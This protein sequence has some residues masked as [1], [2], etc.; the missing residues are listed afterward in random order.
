[1][2]GGIALILGVYTRPLRRS[3]AST[4]CLAA[5]LAH[6]HN[7][8]MFLFAVQGGGYEFPVFW[9]IV[10]FALTLL[11]DGAHA[12]KPFRHLDLA[13]QGRVKQIARSSS[14]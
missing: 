8:W 5:A 13:R 10:C 7:G 9:A 2:T 3:S 11:G 12:F 4:F 6:L 1:M 14:P